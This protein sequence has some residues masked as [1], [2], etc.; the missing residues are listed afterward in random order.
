MKIVSYSTKHYDRKHMEW[1]NQHNG[2]H[3]DIEYFDFNLT[4]QTAKKC[5]WR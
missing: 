5:R 1:V 4:E 2:Y 3:Y